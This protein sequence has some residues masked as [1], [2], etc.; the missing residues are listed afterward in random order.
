MSP[1]P[2]KQAGEEERQRCEASQSFSRPF[3][4]PFGRSSLA[5]LPS[6]CAHP[7]LSRPVMGSNYTP[8]THP[9][10]PSPPHSLAHHSPVP[11]ILPD[12]S[13]FP[14]PSPALPCPA[15]FHTPGAILDCGGGKKKKPI[16]RQRS[17][18]QRQS[19]LQVQLMRA[20]RR[21]RRPGTLARGR[22]PAGA[23]VSLSITHTLAM[24]ERPI[25]TSFL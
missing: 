25:D 5:S 16:S 1:P 18:V 24:G 7:R 20:R 22:V 21:V 17:G 12:Y 19:Q 10:S 23:E 9:S 2:G 8:V 15:L 6:R 13:I 14:Q 4:H 11:T 3:I